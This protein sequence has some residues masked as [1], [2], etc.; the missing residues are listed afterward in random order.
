MA[1]GQWETLGEPADQRVL[2]RV[3]AFAASWSPP[4][5]PSAPAMPVVLAWFPAEQWPIA[6]DRWPDLADDLPADH[7]AYSRRI[8]ARLKWLAKGLPGHRVSIAPLTVAELDAS[9]G[10]RGGTGE[11]RSELAAHVHQ[12][13]RAI[14]WPP[15]RNDR[16]WCGSGR[17]YKQC[18]G[19]EPPAPDRAD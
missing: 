1:R 4:S 18:C 19:P 2:D 7:A 11:A 13:G 12:Q 16:C 9:A 8:E 6:L 5:V 17:K 10:E 3:E 14:D 15:G